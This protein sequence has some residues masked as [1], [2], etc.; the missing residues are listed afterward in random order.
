[1]LFREPRTFHLR[2]GIILADYKKKRYIVA[3]MDEVDFPLVFLR[4]W[5]DGEEGRY[6]GRFYLYDKGLTTDEADQFLAMLKEEEM[7]SL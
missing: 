5:G 1:M 3:R 7:E 2:Y 4:V 6:W